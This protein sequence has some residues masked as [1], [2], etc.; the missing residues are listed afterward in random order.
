ME[1][2]ITKFEVGKVYILEVYEDNGWDFS[3]HKIQIVNRIGNEIKYFDMMPYVCNPTEKGMVY[4]SNGVE[5]F[6]VKFHGME[7]TV[8]ASNVSHECCDFVTVS[9]KS[10]AHKLSNIWGL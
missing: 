1:N 3:L 9:G 2:Q 10:L 8:R 6:T 5:C 4:V 7:N